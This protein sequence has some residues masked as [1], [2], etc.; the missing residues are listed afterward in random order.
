MLFIQVEFSFFIVCH[1]KKKIEI[2]YPGMTF[3]VDGHL[4]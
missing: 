4:L 2:K 3:L 1:L